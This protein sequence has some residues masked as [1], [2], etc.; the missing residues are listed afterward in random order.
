M[1]LKASP[2]MSG[3][4]M[5]GA[6]LCATVAVWAGSEQPSE[7]QRAAS[8]AAPRPAAPPPA[9]FVPYVSAW[10]G[11][12]YDMPAAAA[13]GIKEFTLGFVVSGDGCAPAWDSGIPFDDP[14]LTARIEATRRA[15]GDVRISFGGADGTELATACEDASQLAAA[16]TEVIERYGIIRA[17]FD[18]EGDALDDAAATARRAQ[19]IA[20]VQRTHEGLNVS[21]TLPAMPDGLTPAALSQLTAARQEGVTVSSVN[22]MAMNYSGD[23]TGDM[24]Q[25][26]IQAA[27]AAHEKVRGVLGLSDA[28]AWKTLAVTPMIG[29]N[30]VTGEVF[31]LEDA[32][33]LARFA[34]RKGIGRLSMWSAERDRPCAPEGAGADDTGSGTDSGTDADTG[35][36][37]GDS[38]AAA[39]EQPAATAPSTSCS[40]I[41]QRLGAFEA[42]LSG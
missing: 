13:R 38:G 29:V 3:I 11:S 41:P 26:A 20:L 36:G 39:P 1:R 40:G 27:T 19:A 31:T 37:T 4:A 12:R 30:D 22:V 7:P 9:D 14:A 35:S 15:G 10:A 34:A 21:F 23:H 28:A 42:A 16:Y 18:I 5:A 6:V 17:D 24:G 8:P 32:A 25:Y 2:R 33:G